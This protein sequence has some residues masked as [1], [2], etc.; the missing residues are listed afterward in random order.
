MM[1]AAARVGR[2]RCCE[3]IACKGKMGGLEEKLKKMLEECCRA[4]A[5]KGADVISFSM[6]RDRDGSVVK[7]WSLEVHHSLHGPVIYLDSPWNT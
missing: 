2:G 7:V 5:G 1:L 4:R 6:I 3:V